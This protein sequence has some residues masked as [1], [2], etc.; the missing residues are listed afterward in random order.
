MA[1]RETLL[2]TQ[3]VATA[4]GVGVSTIKRWVDAGELKAT[5]TV[6]KHRLISLS[7]ALRFAGKAGHSTAALE[8]LGLEL[9][10]PI[11]GMPHIDQDLCDRLV[12]ALRQ[13]R[14]TDA[15]QLIHQG[16]IAGEGAVGLSDNLIRPVMEQIGHGWMMGS[17]DVFQEHEATQVLIST[18]T[19]LIIQVTKTQLDRNCL[20]IGAAPE[21]DHYSLAGL[22]GQLVL[23]EQGWEVRNL[24]SNLPLRS[25]A[26]A[27]EEYRPRMVFLSV[28][29]ITDIDSFITEYGLF[30]EVASRMDVAVML[31]GRALWSD[32]R[33]KLVYASFG[34][35]MAHLAEFARRLLPSS[36]SPR[37]ASQSSAI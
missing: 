2:K 13:G 5:R 4:L 22:L 16:Y 30:Y 11:L 3:Q 32:L 17:L 37:V 36:A 21:G 29:H 28:S 26:L 12:E 19:E 33:T 34:D 27:V 25:L 6:G 31:G 23:C 14:S 9:A 15:R 10:N 20:A 24:G 1:N 8:L 18:I 35:R 7:E